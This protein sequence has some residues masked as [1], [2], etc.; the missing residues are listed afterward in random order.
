MSSQALKNRQDTARFWVRMKT[1]DQFL[2]NYSSK[3]AHTMA[4]ALLYGFTRQNTITIAIKIISIA[5]TVY[6]WMFWPHR[7]KYF[8]L[9][10][11][12]IDSIY[13]LCII[14][15]HLWGIE[16]VSEKIAPLLVA[17][18]IHY[19]GLLIWTIIEQIS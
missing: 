18:F 15:C 8:N 9:L 7:P 6:V 16:S 1:E 2:Q 13:D 11:Y 19:I 3:C 17:I 4:Y 12:S 10:I 5:I 14:F